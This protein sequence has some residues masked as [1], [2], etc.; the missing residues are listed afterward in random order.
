MPELESILLAAGCGL[1]FGLI[2]S[3]PVGPVNLAIIN[4]GARRG[5]KFALTL[6]LGAS[7]MEMIYASIAFTG[8][9]GFFTQ[10]L[11]KTIMEIVSFV[12]IMFLGLKFLMVKQVPGQGKVGGRL[13][14][15][16]HPKSAFMTGFVRVLGNPGILGGWIVFGAFMLAHDWVQPT[17]ASK[18]AC[19]LGIGGGTN[20]WF[21]TLSYGVSRGY[22]KFSDQTLVRIERG[23]GIGLILLGL[24]YGCR[25]VWQLLI[26]H[27][28]G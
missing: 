27:H 3:V 7:I 24:F 11:V 18:S 16:L 8:F 21:S 28:A 1:L 12:F 20:L 19:V 25:L 13:E 2:L 26:A 4:E 6:G 22:K 9:A 17:W 15:R 5:F 10:G 23:S 14:E